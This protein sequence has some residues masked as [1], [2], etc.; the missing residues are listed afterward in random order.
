MPRPKN[1]PIKMSPIDIHAFYPKIR[2]YVRKKDCGTYPIT[3]REL[4][5][6]A[7]ANPNNAT[8]SVLRMRVKDSVD[9]LI[10]R[11]LMQRVSNGFY[12][13][14]RYGLVKEG[15]CDE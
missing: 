15:R 3:I 9:R 12:M 1:D 2:D 11:K 5:T 4:E 13:L 7:K 6:L 14:T 8:S 10:L